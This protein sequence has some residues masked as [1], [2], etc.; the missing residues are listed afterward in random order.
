[1]W[2]GFNS[3]PDP[4]DVGIDRSLEAPV[5][6]PAHRLEELEA[7][8]DATRIG[9][10]KGEKVEGHRRK[11]DR[12]PSNRDPPLLAVETKGSDLEN[13]R[14]PFRRTAQNSAYSG[15]QLARTERLDHIIVDADIESVEAI[16]LIG[17]SREHDDRYVRSLADPRGNGESV[18]GGKHPVEHDEIRLVLVELSQRRLS[19][20]GHDH[21]EACLLQVLADGIDDPLLIINDE[22]LLRHGGRQYTRAVWEPRQSCVRFV[23]PPESTVEI[24]VAVSVLTGYRQRLPCADRGCAAR[25]GA[26]GV[27]GQ[28][29][30]QE[31]AERALAHATADQ[32]EVL[33]FSG[34]THLTRFAVNTIHQNVTEAN[35]SVRVR[36]ILGKKTG[37]ASGND[38]G[39][40]GLA[41]AVKKAEAAASFQK[42]NPEFV[43]LPTAQ[44]APSVDAYIP[45]TAE[46]TPELRADGVGKILEQARANQ[47]EAAGAFSTEISE[48]YVAN[49]LGV[50]AYHVGTLANVRTVLM[51]E[52]SSGYGGQTS[53]DVNAIDPAAIGARAVDKALRSANPVE[54]E[55]GEYTVILEE[56]AVGDMLNALAFMGFGALAYQEKRSFMSGRLGEKITGDNITIW[57]DGLDT[58]AIPMPFDFEGVPKQKVTLIENGV[59]KNVV[60]DSFASGR[61]EGATSTGH[62]LPS[63]NTMGPIP[64][65]LFMA[66][67]DATKEEML[68][69]I[70]RG[71]WVTRFHYTNPL[72]PV[73]TVLTGMT[74]DGT[75]LIENGKITKPVKNLRFTQSILDALA[76]ADR[77]GST[78]ATLKS[79]YGSFAIVA[80]A[81]RIQGFRFTGTTDF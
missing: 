4:L 64:V 25:K 28:D 12:F 29:R 55:P 14:F 35:T 65:N 38:V 16:L 74:R 41:R 40:D 13:R 66:T 45:A 81:L 43:S 34:E 72:H 8:E 47:L 46:C 54:I 21:L 56:D 33:V 1:V 22:N 77:I 37:V 69:G 5:R 15:F 11:L 9:H 50:R 48:V 20:I 53:I 59:A 80:P 58:S 24:L 36:S 18:E 68:E 26:V 27:L 75:F 49:S 67:G 63:P 30:L 70:E 7:G 42:D 61:E 23:V 31:I 32:T 2:I 51:G 71:I 39:D 57:D 17:P 79:M 10:Q 62:A 6:L 19:V 44:T 78:A 73:K 52:S 60:Y 76:K 3:L